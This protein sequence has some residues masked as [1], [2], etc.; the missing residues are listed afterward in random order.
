MGRS[1]AVAWV[2]DWS[3][4]DSA[5]ESGAL[6]VSLQRLESGCARLSRLAGDSV[7]FAFLSTAAGGCWHFRFV[8]RWSVFSG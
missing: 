8:G 5:G 2:D 4:L 3:L 1:F 6:F 7:D